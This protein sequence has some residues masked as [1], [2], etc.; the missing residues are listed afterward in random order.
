MAKKG[1]RQLL[2]LSCEVCN[3]N[4]FISEKNKINTPDKLELKKYCKWC[5][6]YTVHKE[7]TKLK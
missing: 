5:R 4:N 2:L 3:H 7:K 6:K 1:H